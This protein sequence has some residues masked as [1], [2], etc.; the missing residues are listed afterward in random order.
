MPDSDWGSD[1]G[2]V[3]SADPD[4]VKLGGL[5]LEHISTLAGTIYGDLF[6]T[7]DRYPDL[8]GDGSDDISKSLKLNYVEPAKDCLSFVRHLA[9]LL[10]THGDKTFQLGGLFDDVNQ[11]S[12]D[13][14]GGIHG[15]KH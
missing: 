5:N 7:V 2:T 10:D 6:N 1:D 8:G 4:E 13:Q 3:F 9:D 15:N 11:T 12:S 14:A